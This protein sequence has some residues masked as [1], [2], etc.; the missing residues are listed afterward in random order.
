VLLLLFGL[1]K[2]VA[3]AGEAVELARLSAV[4]VIAQNLALA[5]ISFFAVGLG[6]RRTGAATLERL[7]LVWPTVRQA[8]LAVLVGLGLA[9]VLLGLRALAPGARPA[10]TLALALVGAAGLPFSSWRWRLA[11]RSGWRS[12]SVA[13]FSRA[14]R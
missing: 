10:D 12:C 9:A 5:V 14:T 1:A 3:S 4:E 2:L 8:G 7:G 6:L 13:R 11:V